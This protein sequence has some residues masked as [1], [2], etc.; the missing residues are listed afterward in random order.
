MNFKT[1][2]VKK[3]TELDSGH[4]LLVITPLRNNW[5]AVLG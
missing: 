2:N 1:V 3:K 4:H 5:H